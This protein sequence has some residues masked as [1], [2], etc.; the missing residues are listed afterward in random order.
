LDVTSPEPIPADHPLCSM[1][2]VI[3]VPH[4]GTATRACRDNMARLAAQNIITSLS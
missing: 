3:I 4:I 1:E 2:S